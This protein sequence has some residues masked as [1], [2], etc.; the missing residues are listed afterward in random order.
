MAMTA[1]VLY[2]A[3]DATRAATLS[4]YIVREV[5]RGRV[6]FDG[7]LLTDDLSMQALRGTL[8]ERTAAAREAGCDIALHCN[9]RMA[10]MEQVAAAAGRLDAARRWR[11]QPPRRSEERRRWAEGVGAGNL[12]GGARQ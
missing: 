4:P 12:W 9:G 6:G 2:P 1:H 5:I 3:W 10:E 8:A 7:L 11:W